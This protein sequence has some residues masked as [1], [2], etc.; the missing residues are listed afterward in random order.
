MGVVMTRRVVITGLGAV[1][2]VGNTVEDSWANLLQGKSGIDTV[3]AWCEEKWANECMGVTCGG[4]VKN[5]NAE[6]FVEPKKDV[7]RMGRFIHLAL[8]ACREAWQMAAL[9][10]K[11]DDVMG[12]RAGCI[13]GV[14]MLGMDVLVD[15]YDS[16]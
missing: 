3:P 14:G 7:R 5:F 2:P 8:A 13:I 16:L 4:E 1:C 15:N 6:D 12:D 10:D 11:L 9:P